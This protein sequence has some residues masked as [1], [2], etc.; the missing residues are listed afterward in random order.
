MPGSKKVDFLRKNTFSLYDLYGNT[1]AQEPHALEVM[2]FTIWVDP[3]LVIISLHLL[4]L[5]YVLSPYPTDATY[6]I[7]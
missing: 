1:L 4:C 2:K 3:S 5:E 7:W 6:Q